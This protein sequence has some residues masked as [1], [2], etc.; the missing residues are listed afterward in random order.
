VNAGFEDDDES[1]VMDNSRVIGYEDSVVMKT[2]S[3][4]LDD[5][6]SHSHMHQ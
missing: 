2:G 3:E 1:I 5:K 6:F 4:L